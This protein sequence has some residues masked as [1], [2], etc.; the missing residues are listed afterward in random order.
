MILLMILRMSSFKIKCVYEVIEFA[1]SVSILTDSVNSNLIRNIV[2]NK[3]LLQETISIPNISIN[4]FNVFL[5]SITLGV[6]LNVK[7]S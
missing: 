4:A 7:Y 1:K 6:I 3:I 5:Y 2:T